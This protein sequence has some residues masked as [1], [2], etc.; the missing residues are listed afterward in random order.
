MR[1]RDFISVVGGTAMAVPFAPWLRAAHAQHD[2]RPVIG[3]LQSS[4][5]EGNARRVDAFL[6]GLEEAGFVDGKNVTIIYRWADNQ[7][8]KLAPLAADLVRHNVAVIATPASMPATRAARAATSSIPIVF[9]T[10]ADPVAAGVVASLSRPGGNVTGVTSLNIDVGSKRLDLLHQLVPQA[11]RCFVLVNPASPV[12]A[13]FI[14]DVRAGASRLDIQIETLR[15][16]TE[17][18]IDAA[19][20]GLPANSDKVL[21]SSPEPFLYSRRAQIIALAARYNVAAGFDTRDY[22]DDGGL[23]SYGA[24]FLD[25]LRRAGV[26]VGRILK[27]ERPASLPVEQSDKFELAINLR[28]AKAL[29]LTIPA[30]LLA[31]ADDVIE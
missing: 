10:G 28:T 2:E 3:M 23:L 25:V 1:R 19:F 11:K 5:L 27:G 6:R 7:V 17:S 13:S 24:N 14:S 22:V 30:Q 16:G 15:A 4:S 29:G 18:E 9:A 8:E 26:Y 21:L 31:V 12:A 20:A